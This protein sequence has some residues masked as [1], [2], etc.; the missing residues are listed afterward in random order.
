L[1]ALVI[2]YGSIG[3]RHIEN[4]SR[5][6][7]HQII[8]C[9]NRK[10]D[11]FLK[12]NKCKIVTSIE[13]GIK[14]KPDFAII[15]N[16]TNLHISAALKLANAGIHF[17][18]EKPLSNNLKNIKKLL[19]LVK[20]KKLVTLMGSNFRFYPGIK[21]MKKMIQNNEIGKVIFVHAENGSYLPSWHPKEDYRQ[22]YAARNDLGGGVVL[23]CIHEIDYLYWFFGKINEVY[24]ITGK[25]GN[26]NITAD[27]TSSILLK[28]KNNVI[29]EIHLD[30]FQEPSVRSCKIV[31]TKG[32]I[33]LDLIKN[34]VTKYVKNSKKI[35]SKFEEKS[36]DYNSMYVD[37]LNY[38]IKCVKKKIIPINDVQ[39]GFETLKI[40]MAITKSGQKN[41]RVCIR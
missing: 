10:L 34:S 14:E 39:I 11:N 18:C 9:T 32:S 37:E 13:S 40:A 17:V 24:S 36:F 15:A 33:H 30:Y 8:V 31:G 20:R 35:Y 28:F 26:L 25:Y 2:G 21:I 22:S 4:I 23:T 38:F 6:S 5:L 7:E 12:K 41:M 16:V 19:N 29:G 27:D 3:K 1:K